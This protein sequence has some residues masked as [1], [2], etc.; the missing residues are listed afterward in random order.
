MRMHINAW[1]KNFWQLASM[2]MQCK[3]QITLHSGI[4]TCILICIFVSM[5][6]FFNFSVFWND[7]ITFY[8]ISSSSVMFPVVFLVFSKQ[9]QKI[10]D[11]VFH[12]V[13]NSQKCECK[14]MCKCDANENCRWLIC[15]ECDANSNICTTSHDTQPSSESIR[16]LSLSFSSFFL[17]CAAFWFNSVF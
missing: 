6:F 9:T 13:E 15:A 3:F 10:M 11:A 2:Q 12:I 7:C 14:L 1:C 4:G 16:V 17:P 8:T 5:D